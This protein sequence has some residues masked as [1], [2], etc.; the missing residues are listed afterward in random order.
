MGKFVTLGKVSVLLAK[1]LKRQTTK[2]ASPQHYYMLWQ[3]VLYG[4][5]SGL[6]TLVFTTQAPH[7]FLLRC[8][9]TGFFCILTS[10]R[11]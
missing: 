11:I 3:Q 5:P 4:K 8:G 9:S 2:A 1:Y 7:C 6:D 10:H